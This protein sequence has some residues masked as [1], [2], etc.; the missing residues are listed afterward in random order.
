MEPQGGE[1]VQFCTQ[2]V[3]IAD[4]SHA[5]RLCDAVPT[6]PS[7][8]PPQP[9]QAEGYGVPPPPPS[10]HGQED[11]TASGM[12]LILPEHCEVEVYTAEEPRSF[13]ST[14]DLEAGRLSIE[15]LMQRARADS[16]E[17]GGLLVQVLPPP[18]PPPPPPAEEH[19]T[20]IPTEPPPPPAPPESSQRRN[21]MISGRFNDQHKMNYMR[22]VKEALCDRSVPVDMVKADFASAKFGNQTAL[23]LY[24]AKALLAF[25]TWDY[26]EKTGAQ[27]E[28]YIELEYAH[29]NK[30]AI[31]PIQL[32]HEF[33]PVPKMRKAGHKMFW[34]FSAIWYGSSTKT[35]RTLRGL[36]RRSVMPGSEQSSI[37]DCA[38]LEDESVLLRVRWTMCLHFV[39][40]VFLHAAVACHHTR[41][42]DL[43]TT[44]GHTSDFCRRTFA[45]SSPV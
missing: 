38:A 17:D 44:F 34:C 7:N 27:Y 24:R 35:C 36:P 39:I 10:L 41:T 31:L 4:S 22:Q 2:T 29:Q 6:A 26:G 23:L 19:Q 9:P 14:G 37:C 30:L 42:A 16:A 8:L 32:C 11:G 40:W 43:P 5:F 45:N 18:P 21:L 20:A 1:N 25:C 12:H 3:D 28:T 13:L 33:P 15:Q